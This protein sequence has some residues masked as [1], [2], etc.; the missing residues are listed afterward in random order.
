MGAPEQ[1]DFIYIFYNYINLNIYTKY[2]WLMLVLWLSDVRC[3][4]CRHFCVLAGLR[5]HA[6]GGNGT[7]FCEPRRKR[8]DMPSQGSLPAPDGLICRCRDIYIKKKSQTDS[9]TVQPELRDSLTGGVTERKEGRRA[10]VHTR[11][12]TQQSTSTTI[13]PISF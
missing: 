13:C 2:W 9:E 7:L 11:L 4:Y 8:Y 3:G 10:A 12:H 1:Q 5:R 6:G